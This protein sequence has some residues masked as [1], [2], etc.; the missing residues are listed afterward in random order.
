M[1]QPVAVAQA[2]LSDHLPLKDFIHGFSRIRV[3]GNF[4]WMLASLSISLPS[5]GSPFFYFKFNLCLC[6]NFILYFFWRSICTATLANKRSQA[7]TG[8]DDW[9]LLGII[10]HDSCGRLVSRSLYWRENFRMG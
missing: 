2:A 6:W 4:S 10:C 7:C 1:F 9:S 8:E 3:A 5:T